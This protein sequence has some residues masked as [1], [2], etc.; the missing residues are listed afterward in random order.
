MGGVGVG[1]FKD[2]KEGVSQMVKVDKKY[3]P[4]K[5]NSKTYKELYDIYCRIYEGMEQKDIFRCLAKFQNKY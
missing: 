1:I 2:I 4:N 5:E 3:E